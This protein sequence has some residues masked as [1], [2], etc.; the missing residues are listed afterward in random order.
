MSYERNYILL[1]RKVNVLT[2]S[3]KSVLSKHSKY[4]H[5]VSEIFK[6]SNFYIPDN[7]YENYSTVGIYF[8]WEIRLKSARYKLLLIHSFQKAHNIKH[9]QL[10]FLLISL[11]FHIDFI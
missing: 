11:F 6:H 5:R 4:I 1:H 9:F 10:L 7:L 2:H 8:D 3:E